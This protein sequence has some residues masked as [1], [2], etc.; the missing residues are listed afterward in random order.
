VLIARALLIATLVASAAP[1]D[2]RQAGV[3]PDD[4]QSIHALLQAL[5]TALSK[6]D[7]EAWLALQSPLA[8][9][10]AAAEF[11][12]TMVPPAVTRA[13]VR[14]RDRQALLGTLPGDGY[15]LMAEVFTES[16]SRGRIATWRVD[17]R[18]PRDST[19]LQPW[20]ISGQ[21][22]LSTVD[23][24]HRLSLHPNKQFVARDL[25]VKSVDF[26]LRLPSGEAFI[27]ETIEGVTAMVLLGDGSMV[28][29][30]E[31]QEER[32]QVRLFAGTDTLDVPFTAAFVRIN[33]FDFDQIAKAQSLTPATVV[34]Q[35]AFRRA[36]MIFE[37]D[38]SKSFSL[39]LNELSRDTWSLL[40]QFGDFVAEVRTRR[41]QTLTFA[42]STG[43]AE[44]VSLFH[45]ERKRNISAYASPMKL[46]SRGRFFNED[47]LVEYDV[48]DY[49]IEAAFFPE[50]EWLEGRTR[51]RIRVKSFALAALT[52]RLGEG[53]TVKT[54]SSDQLGRMLFL[55]VRN[56]NSIVVNLPSPVA[57][58]FELTLVV[59]YAGRARSQG[60]DSESLE[61]QGG[62]RNP[63]DMPFIPAEPNW[64]FSNRVQ[65][66]PQGQVSDYATARIRFTVPGEYTVV[67]SGMPQSSAPLLAPSVTAGAPPRATY[68]FEA[69]QPLRY[70]GVVVSKFTRVD[71]ATV[72]L[73]IVPPAQ[74]LVP[75]TAK[76]RATDAPIGSRNTISLAVEAN[77]RQI[78]RGR[79]VIS[80]AADILRLF[81]VLVGDVPYDAMTIA[82]V[83]NDRPGGHS[84]GY[85]AVINNPLPITTFQF[86]N[87]PAMFSNFPEFYTA[88]EL[89]HQWWGQAVGWKNY[90][91]QWLSEGFAQYFAALYAKHRRGEESFRDVL[92]QFRRWAMD[93]SDQGAIYLGYR[94][95]HI[96]GDS[97][98]FRALVYNKGASVLHMLRR[99]I[100]DDAF[101]RGVRLYY[102]ENRFKK[103][104]TED[105]QRAM[106]A[107]SGQSLDRF[108]QRWIFESGIPRVRYSTTIEGQEAVVR[109]EQTADVYDVPVTV[110]FEYA[111]RTVEEI[112]LLTAAQTEKRFPLAG[113]LRGIEINADHAALAHFEK[114]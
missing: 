44:D 78:G 100:G 41:F 70:I 42:R 12:D 104:G 36:Q 16:G 110:S 91:E 8:D 46:S 9:S 33:P 20:R 3:Q 18:R 90:H 48:L 98:V 108:F 60:I 53:F 10:N 82:M 112:M 22:K 102:A 65:W 105:L 59:D 107:A 79:D 63:D 52:L 96:K 55:R 85:F 24:L 23:G 37:D 2:A 13:V 86:R 31:P 15:S 76:T 72:A 17:I 92:R 73:E 35:R 5:E 43:E 56:Q 50:R 99:L 39:D 75:A 61:V 80:T 27:A 28:F 25:V 30:P 34:D 32:G 6:S 29:T 14:E 88:H 54:I 68:V 67:G 19:D 84:P 7:R 81:S 62:Q 69:R 94:L 51:L 49:D 38:V 95:G 83:E 111:D 71:E 40:P 1:A 57:R 66:Y 74:P 101:F 97:R 87:D 77:K 21:E 109:F 113:S 114:R 4:E 89:A 11:F 103:A 58:D 93:Q 64:L 47:N 45:R 106:E 26:E